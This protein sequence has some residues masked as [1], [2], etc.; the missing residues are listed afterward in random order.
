MYMH[1][2]GGSISMKMPFQHKFWYSSTMASTHPLALLHLIASLYDWG[3]SMV[4]NKVLTSSSMML[5][6]GPSLLVT[7]M[8]VPTETLADSW[9]AGIVVLLFEDLDPSDI[10]VSL[11]RCAGGLPLFE[12]VERQRG[13]EVLECA[14]VLGL[15]SW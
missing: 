9:V 14:G 11:S 5:S 8:S 10:L 12:Q 15:R 13:C 3:A 1:V 2:W 7:F 4:R 6:H